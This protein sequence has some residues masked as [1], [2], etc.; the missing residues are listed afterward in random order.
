MRYRMMQ[1]AALLSCAVANLPVPAQ[2][3]DCAQLDA[4]YADPS[5][6]YELR[7]VPLNSE[8]AAASGRFHVTVA[9]LGTAMEGFVMP[10]D[11]LVSS[12]GILMFGCPEGD[13]TGAEIS[14]CTVWQGKLHGTTGAGVASNLQAENGPATSDVVLTGFGK[15]VRLSRLW[16]EGKV[17]VAPED[18]LTF[19]E[20]AG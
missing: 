5:G 14:A 17:T 20:C 3:A 1:A 15:A 9:G 13:A 8:A 18:V 12:D 2:A 10:A 16:S 11:D 6:A 4:I 19:K 7:F